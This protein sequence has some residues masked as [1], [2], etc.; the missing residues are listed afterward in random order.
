MVI[1]VVIGCSNRSERDKHVSYYRIP[2]VTAKYGER[3]LEL[4]KKCQAGFLAIFREDIDR[5]K[6]DKYRICSNILFQGVLLS[7]QMKP[8]LTGFQ[9]YIWGIKAKASC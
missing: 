9:L 7:K 3:H 4:S 2:S 6:L 1:C 5:K 8:T